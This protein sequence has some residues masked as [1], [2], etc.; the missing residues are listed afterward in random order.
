MAFARSTS[1]LA[2]LTAVSFTYTLTWSILLPLL[3]CCLYPRLSP[4]GEAQHP[5]GAVICL[6]L[7]L[8][9]LTVFAL[10]LATV[11]GVPGGTLLSSLC[12]A[13]TTLIF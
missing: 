5:S 7:F 12:L 9:P 13:L 10:S 6:L 4:A 2:W 8:L 3:F 11:L 1:L